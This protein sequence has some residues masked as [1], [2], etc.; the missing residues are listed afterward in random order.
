MGDEEAQ[1]G[2]SG[3]TGTDQQSSKPTESRKA[4]EADLEG[5]YTGALLLAI[6]SSSIGG[7]FQ[8]GYHIGCINVPSQ[9][10]KDWFRDSHE[11]L[12]GN[13]LEEKDIAKY[14]WGITVSLF[15]V[16]GMVGGLACGWAADRFGR[17]GA[18][19]ANNVVA[20]LA[21][22]FM[23]I[24]RFVNTYHLI[25]IGRILIGINAGASSGLVPMYLI[26]ISPVN[27]RGTIGSIPQFMVTFSIL[28]SQ[29]LGLPQVLGTAEHWPLIFAFTAVPVLIQVCTLPFCVESPKYNLIVRDLA[30][31]AEE[32]L[33]K[34]RGKNDVGAEMDIMREEAA[35]MAKVEKV[36]MGDLF[37]GSLAWPMFIAIMMMIAQ[38]FS[39]INVA[40][41]FST[42]IFEGAGL[43][44]NAIYATLG[45]G[46]CNVLMTVASVFLV[47]KCGRRILLLLG[48]LGMLIA[49]V[50]LTISISL[51]VANNESNQW[52]AYLSMLFVFGFVISFAT[53]PGS[54]PWFFVSELFDSGARG[55]AN[56]VA[57]NVNW[58]SNFIVGLSWEFLNQSL[59]HYAFLI[60]ACFQGFFI[61]FVY[62]Y[63]PETKGRSIEDIKQEM[64]RGKSIWARQGGGGD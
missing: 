19:I 47:D 8:F 26:E 35:A 20:M 30:E 27:L 10:M 52:A 29:I 62:V 37:K 56:S 25:M 33:K 39:G 61:F 38:Q 46:A 58:T 17:K 16:G 42:S 31:Q 3:G 11:I 24:A 12:T 28:F 9:V 34:L 55:G 53:G 54:I 57:A 1:R 41:F 7:S 18:M 2:E 36:K 6:L 51:Y 48:L 21:A 60:F 32:D 5:S 64:K 49:S 40:M 59:K 4:N 50:L 14:Q 23:S 45:M 43:K 15:A 22:L 13:K 44:D 63:V